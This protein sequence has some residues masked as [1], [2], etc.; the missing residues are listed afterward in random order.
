MVKILITIWFVYNLRM[1]MAIVWINKI[2]AL[3]VVC[4]LFYIFTDCP[5]VVGFV[6]IKT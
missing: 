3:V 1:R 4:L 2:A 5:L 6:N